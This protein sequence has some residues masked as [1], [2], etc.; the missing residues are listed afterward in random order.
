MSVEIVQA[1]EETR[2]AVAAHSVRREADGRFG[3]KFDPRWFGV[4]PR[5]RPDL[6]DIRCPTLRLRGE[7]SALLAREA[8]LETVSAIPDAPLV[9]IPGGEHIMQEY[10]H[11][12]TEY[13]RR[14]AEK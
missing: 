1:G 4:P 5:R 6:R 3:F 10:N 13:F 14:M 7:N 11:L 8:A 9:E 2:R 12:I